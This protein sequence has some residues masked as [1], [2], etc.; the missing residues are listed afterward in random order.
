MTFF[1][2]S[3]ID[4]MDDGVSWLDAVAERYADAILG[5]GLLREEAGLDF[6]NS[7]S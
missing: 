4:G 7:R 6:V 1:A 3:S 5:R 2:L